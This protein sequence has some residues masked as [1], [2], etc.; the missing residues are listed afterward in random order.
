MTNLPDLAA[1]A[2]F[3]DWLRLARKASGLSVDDAASRLGLCAEELRK[4]E[5]ALARRLPR[6]LLVEIGRLYCIPAAEVLAMAGGAPCVIPEPDDLVAPGTRGWCACGWPLADHAADDL[7]NALYHATTVRWH[8]RT[9]PESETGGGHVVGYRAALLASTKHPDE[10]Q[11]ELRR[12]AAV[13]LP[14]PEIPVRKGLV[15]LFKVDP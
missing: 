15:E 13:H 1:H 3:G 8:P 12:R 9:G 7:A 6:S 10:A 4:I 2:R 11:E 5:G 14:L